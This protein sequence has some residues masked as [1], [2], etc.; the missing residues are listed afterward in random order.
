M[1]PAGGPV[2]CKM[3]IYIW[4]NMV[5][6]ATLSLASSSPDVAGPAVP[7]L[8]DLAKMRVRVTVGRAARLAVGFTP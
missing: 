8:A 7:F 2:M 5:A 4:D 3:H 1:L 6:I